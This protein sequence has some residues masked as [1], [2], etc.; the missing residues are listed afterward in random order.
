[1]S[2]SEKRW[3]I[4]LGVSFCAL[5]ERGSKMAQ[6]VVL[7][8]EASVLLMETNCRWMVGKIVD[9]TDIICLSNTLLSAFNA[10]N[11]R[12]EL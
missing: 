4:P 1:M 3:R 11:V 7:Q 2:A 6:I 5:A 10:L 12:A 8:N 9:D